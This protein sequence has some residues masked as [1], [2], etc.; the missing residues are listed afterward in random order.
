MGALEA[1]AGQGKPK[2]AYL[3][4]PGE[5]IWPETGAVRAYFDRKFGVF[6][7]LLGD[8]S[9]HWEAL[10]KLKEEAAGLG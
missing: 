1:G 9:R 3:S 6:E 4:S 2:D 5:E 10:A 7:K 8:V